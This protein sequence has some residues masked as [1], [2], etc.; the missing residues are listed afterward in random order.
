MAPKFISA[1]D[2]AVFIK[3]ECVLWIEGSS[4]G[5]NEPGALYEAVSKRFEEDGHPK[6]IT[7]VHS[8]GIG[9]SK[10]LGTDLFAREGLV[11]CCIGGHYGFA[12]QMVKMINENKLEAYN[13]PQG[14]IA[15]L[16]REIASGRPGLITHVG[17]HTFVDPRITGGALNSI[18]KRKLVEVI[19]VKGKEY[20][21]YPSFSI[22]VV[23]VRGTSADEDGNISMEDEVSY[24]NMLAAAQAGHN[25]GGIV[26]AQVKRKVKKGSLDA[27]L[28]KIPG[29]LV[30]YVVVEEK[31]WQSF[32]GEYNP[33][34]CGA[35]KVVIASTIERELSERKIVARRAAM[36]LIPGVINLGFGMS[37]E[38]ASVAAEEGL[39]EDIVLTIEQGAVGGVPASGLIFGCA[40]NPQAIVDQPNQFDFYDGGGIDVTF[41]GLAQADQYGNV[42]V[43][44][45]GSRIAGAG[46]FINITQG[47]KSIVYCGTFT[48]GGLKI[49]IED[50][51]LKIL[52]EGKIKKFVSQV[53]HITFSGQ[54][55]QTRN[56]PVL[57]VTE[58]AVFELTPEGV[59]LIEIA[60]GIDLEKDILANMEFIP[61][62]AKDLKEMNPRIFMSEVMGIKDIILNKQKK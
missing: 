19:D 41:L 3:D 22:D 12:N 31:Q 27:R 18:S 33:A 36:E 54:F 32:V 56:T 61:E 60:P 25:C 2:A 40:M 52:N 13:I 38:V 44:K 37:S 46:G 7:L 43:S 10:G 57:Y 29:I 23:F 6:D 62:I 17:L 24:L 39:A 15:Q 8:N 34:L 48:A 26:I 59:T 5:L 11:K 28:V 45:F 30:D 35:A 51:K 14:V 42:N 1:K 4:G 47:A 16:A 53:E 21:F 49:A 9:D 58:R 20:L 50:G 55:A